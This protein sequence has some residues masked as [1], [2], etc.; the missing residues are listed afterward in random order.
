M[1][2]DGDEIV[3]SSLRVYAIAPRAWVAALAVAILSLVELA[4]V[5]VCIMFIV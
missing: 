3:I 1:L 2:S 5:V 4:N